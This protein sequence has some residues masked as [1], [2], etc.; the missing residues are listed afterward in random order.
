VKLSV[1]FALI[2]SCGRSPAETVHL[3]FDAD[4]P[5]VAFA[6]GDI[7]AAL[8]KRK[9]TVE[10]RS[11]AALAE[12]DTGKKIVLAVAAGSKVL[13]LL[14]AQGGKAVSALGPQAYALRTTTRPGVTYWVLGGDAA[15]AMYGGLQMAE[16]IDFNGLRGSFDLEEAP[17][18]SHR[19][20]KL[21]LPLELIAIAQRTTGETSRRVE[22]GEPGA[23]LLEPLRRHGGAI[24][25]NGA[26]A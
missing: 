6:A 24:I 18:L 22:R 25:L 10:N 21:N 12:G 3:Y 9:H 7:K 14:A 13:S 16:N 15:G 1:V 20:M 4:T 8:E 26:N 5:Q 11:L 23:T 17:Y 2:A 19:G